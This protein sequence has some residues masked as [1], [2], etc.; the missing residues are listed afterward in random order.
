ML[1]R[2]NRYRWFKVWEADGTWYGVERKNIV[3]GTVSCGNCILGKSKEE[4][5]DRIE[6]KCKYEELIENGMDKRE[7]MRTALFGE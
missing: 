2:Y 5:V 7:A 3:N 4:I 1:V 6:A